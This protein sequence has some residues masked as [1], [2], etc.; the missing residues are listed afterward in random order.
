MAGQFSAPASL[1]PEIRI[2]RPQKSASADAMPVSA[3]AA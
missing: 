3:V 1:E 2:A